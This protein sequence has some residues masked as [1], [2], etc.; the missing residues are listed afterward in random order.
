MRMVGSAM[1]ESFIKSYGKD[2]R[3]MA[4]T[5]YVPTEMPLKTTVSLLL[6][7]SD[8]HLKAVIPSK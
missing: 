4:I 5:Q 8:L 7:R 2:N 1:S 3:N 6:I